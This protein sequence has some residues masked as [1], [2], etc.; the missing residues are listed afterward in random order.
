M[1]YLNIGST[2]AGEDCLPVGHPG[3]RRECSIFARQLKREFP[4]GDFRVKGFEHDFGRYYEVVAYYI[5]G[6][7]SESSAFEAEGNASESWDEQS[8]QE[9]REAVGQRA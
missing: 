1:E 5:E 2:P 9:L 4:E 7:P 3:A 8:L 6:E